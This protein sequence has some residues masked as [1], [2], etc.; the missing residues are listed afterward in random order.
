L[1]E[2]RASLPTGQN[3]LVGSL[4][5]PG[6]CSGVRGA[7]PSTEIGGI[8]PAPIGDEQRPAHPGNRSS[9]PQRKKN[10][11]P[12]LNGV[13]ELV[14]DTAADKPQSIPQ[15][16]L[17]PSCG[18]GTKSQHV[19]PAKRFKQGHPDVL[20]CLRIKVR[21]RQAEIRPRIGFLQALVRTHVA[22]RDRFEANIGHAASVPNRTRRLTCVGPL[23][24]AS[25]RK[26]H[27][28]R[29]GSRRN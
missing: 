27:P 26:C 12:K 28:R 8:A 1:V 13:L 17:H 9:G 15:V 5:R 19:E 16:G 22:K 25:V 6:L 7:L 29:G 21:T 2:S 11:G 4:T 10:V 14:M 3:V 20:G 18:L 23:T 24:W